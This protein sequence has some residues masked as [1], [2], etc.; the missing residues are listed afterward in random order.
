V[1]DTP[2]PKLVS[3]N[4]QVSVPEPQPLPPSPPPPV[5]TEWPVDVSLRPVKT[6]DDGSVMY[7]KVKGSDGSV[8]VPKGTLHWSKQ[9]GD[10]KLFYVRPVDGSGDMKI[11]SPPA[12]VARWKG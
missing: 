9:V 4:V 11:V 8:V 3:P 5:P 10:R 6:N 12:V 1:A 2:K 7:V